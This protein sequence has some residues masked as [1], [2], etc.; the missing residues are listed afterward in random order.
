[1]DP[2]VCREHLSEL[3]REESTLLAELEQLLSR[4]AGI[5]EGSDIREI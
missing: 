3:F 4:E 1:M 2:H 5:L